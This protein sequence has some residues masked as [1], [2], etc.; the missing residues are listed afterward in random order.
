MYLFRVG[1]NTYKVVYGYGVLYKSNLIDRVISVTQINN[2][3][4]AETIKN[5]IGL[6]AE[7][8]L[9]GLQKK[10]KDQFGYETPEE[11]EKQISVICDLLDDYEDE[12][13]EDEKPLNGFTLFSD[14]Q[15]EMERN[16]FLS[17][18]NRQPEATAISEEATIVPQDHKVAKKKVGQK[19]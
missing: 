12:H 5:L 18:I 6:T 17:M 1:G 19:E 16:G 8:L 15:K 9:E 4:P 2:E 3:K 14:L 7:M 13:A 11:R 10:H